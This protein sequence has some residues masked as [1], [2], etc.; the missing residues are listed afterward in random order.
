MTDKFDSDGLQIATNNEIVADLESSFK[1]IYGADINLDQNS[2][3]GQLLNIIAQGQTDVRELLMQLYQSFDPDQASGRLLDERCAINN[4]FR[5]GGNFTTVDITIVTDRTVTLQG[6]DDNYNDPLATGYTIQDNAGNQFVLVNTQT[7]T[8]G[9]NS[10][11]FRAKELGAVETTIGTITTPVTVVL[12]VI[13]VNNPTDSTPGENEETD[14]ELKVRRRQSVSIGSSEYLN[15][16]L[17][18]VLQLDGVT[19]AAL[20]ENVTSEEDDNGTP[21]HCMWLVVEGGSSADIGDLIYR[22]KS[23]GCDMRGDI[24]YN[25]VTP[26]GLTFVSKWDEPTT[27]SLRMK[28][29]IQKKVASASFDKAAIA[30]KIAEYV[31]FRIGDGAETASLTTIAQR[32]IDELGESGYALGVLISSDNGANW[33]EYVAPAVAQ[34]LVLSISASD[35]TVL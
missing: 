3:D 19:D 7:L 13:S 22:K 8:A 16:L 27:K 33:V 11:L 26:S 4:I 14:A 24:T 15:G 25:I 29:N 1:N 5:K 21:P 35:I 20:Y 17:A 30:Q 23:Y 34:K 2:P 6:V 28:F 31:S 12:G 9:T 10:V 18:S 32:A